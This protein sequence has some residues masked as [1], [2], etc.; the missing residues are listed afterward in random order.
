MIILE[1]Q[2]GMMCKNEKS[3]VKK[4]IDSVIDTGVKPDELVFKWQLYESIDNG[5][6]MIPLEYEIFDY[7]YGYA[8]KN[9]FKTTASVF[10]YKSRYFLYKYNV[11]FIKIACK[12][13]KLEFRKNMWQ[14]I[15]TFNFCVSV[16]DSEDYYKIDI[17][18]T[19]KYKLCCIP[20]YPAYLNQYEYDFSGKQ[21]C[22]G[23]SDHTIDFR[24]HDKY[25]PK[26]YEKHYYV[27]GLESYD[28]DW[29]INQSGLNNLLTYRRE[30]L[31][32]A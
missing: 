1:M 14:Y 26:I 7:A 5:L 8:K 16:K 20:D 11:P 19:I 3:V 12:T 15:D 18:N 23:I 24:L 17:K 2:D 27:D 21:L 9:G 30:N 31:G 22:N 28:K 29:S 10:D 25:L 13:N 6:E 32:K 4:M